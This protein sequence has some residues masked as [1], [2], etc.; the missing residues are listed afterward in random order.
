VRNETITLGDLTIMMVRD[1][2]H[3]CMRRCLIDTADVP[4]LDA[5]HTTWHV[6][7]ARGSQTKMYAMGKQWHSE[8]KTMTALM[9][10]RVLLGLADPLVEI[11]HRD[12]DGLNN[13]RFN[14][15]ACT[16]QENLRFR[17]P[18]RDWAAIDAREKFADEYR[19]ERR[20]AADVQRA[21]QLTRAALWKI[22]STAGPGRSPASHAY[23][24]ATAAANV[25]TMHQL[26]E[27]AGPSTKKFG[28]FVNPK[29][30]VAAA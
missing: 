8:T 30:K 10:H 4:L 19:E 21:F 18:D 24:A 12:N 23:H 1:G 28:I 14:L 16:H 9:L 3:K 25:R 17:F 6:N 15:R 29:T 20:I 11:D 2:R 5:L 7:Y 22:R 26:R 27:F 13:R